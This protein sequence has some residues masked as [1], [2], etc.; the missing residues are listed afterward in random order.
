MIT[1]ALMSVVTGLV[2]VLL[3]SL[4]V[5]PVPGWL[6]DLSSGVSS[7]AAA[8]SGLGVWLPVPLIVAVI[9][10][11]FGAWIIGFGIKLARIV[12]SF[13]TLGGGSAA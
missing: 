6:S 1:E 10:T 7:I 2:S 5:V 12:A 9:T 8:G 4:P 3:G 11:V 13:L